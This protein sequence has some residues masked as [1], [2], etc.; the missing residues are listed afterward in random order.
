MREVV[1]EALAKNGFTVGDLDLLV[2][3]QANLRIIENVREALELPTERMVV[4]V[5]RYGNT[6]SASIPLA[7]DECRRQGRVREGALVCLAAFGSGFTWGSA[8][9]RF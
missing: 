3:H 5:E 1:E 7:L 6:T 9:V 4:N 8:L 2:P